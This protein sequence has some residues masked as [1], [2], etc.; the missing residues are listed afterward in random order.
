MP[1]ASDA[2]DWRDRVL[3]LSCDVSNEKDL[4]SAFHDSADWAG[5]IKGLVNNAGVH[6]SGPSRAFSSQEFE[7]IMRINVNAVFVA[8][9]EVYPYLIQN[10]QSLIVNIGSFFARMG[11]K[12]NVAYSASKAAVEA[13]TRCLA[14]EWGSKGIGL[15][16]VAPGYI[17]TE[18][19]RAFLSDE[20]NA[21]KVISRT[22]VGRVGM[23]N[24]VARLIAA[25][26]GE[27]IAFL[28]GET[29][30]VDGGRSMSL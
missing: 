16:T 26:Y 30:V 17:E 22:P 6:G 10:D 21:A 7:R 11:A 14:A 8:A 4:Q 13:M 1:S 23:V 2:A 5:G 18:M 27:R 19:N 29:I 9:R 3:C 12:Y 25:L 20:S 15:L 24:E 28:T